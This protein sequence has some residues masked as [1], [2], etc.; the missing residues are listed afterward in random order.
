MKDLLAEFYRVTRGRRPEHL[1]FFRDGVSEGQFKEVYYVSGGVG[2]GWVV[3][4][5]V[6]RWTGGGRS[7]LNTVLCDLARSRGWPVERAR[8]AA[9][10]AAAAGGAGGWCTRMH[11]LAASSMRCT[12]HLLTRPPPAERVQRCARGVQGDGG[13][14][15]RV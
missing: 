10:Q 11:S 9:L 13:P 7:T 8:L 15:R 4:G 1:I 5:W 14:R 6:V 12:S 3:G 2:G